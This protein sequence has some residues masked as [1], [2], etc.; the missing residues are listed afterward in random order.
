MLQARRNEQ[1]ELNKVLEASKKTAV[2]EEA[3]R[4]KENGT[5]L[6]HG[7]LDRTKRGSKSMSRK[8]FSLFHHKD[9][10]AAQALQDASN[11]DAGEKHEKLKDRLSFGLGRKKSTN[12]LSQS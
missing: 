7:L 12:L 5:V 2:Q 9:K 1:D 6:S 4:K 8:S 3:T 10:G 11:G